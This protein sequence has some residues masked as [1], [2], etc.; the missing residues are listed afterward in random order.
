V[1]S[2][3]SGRGRGVLTFVVVVVGIECNLGG[4]GDSRSLGFRLHLRLRRSVRKRPGPMLLVHLIDHILGPGHILGCAESTLRRSAPR[5]RCL[6]ADVALAR[7]LVCRWRRLCVCFFGVG[8]DVG[9]GAGSRGGERVDVCITS[10]RIQIEKQH[11]TERTFR[12]QHMHLVMAIQ[13]HLPPFFLPFYISLTT[14]FRGGGAFGEECE[15]SSC[16]AVRALRL[17][18]CTTSVHHEHDK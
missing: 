7:R 8:A 17:H 2:R 12:K 6:S 10:F 4:T 18:N 13:F 1:G 5:R 9:I 11:N 16:S 3:A 14:I 15:A